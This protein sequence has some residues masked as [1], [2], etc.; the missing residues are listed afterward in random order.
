MNQVHCIFSKDCTREKHSSGESCWLPFSHMSYAQWIKGLEEQ[1]LGP[2][3][4]SYDMED[5]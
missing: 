3:G 4:T 2:K 5:L 1:A